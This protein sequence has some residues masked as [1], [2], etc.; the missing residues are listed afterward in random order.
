MVI[1][2]DQWVLTSSLSLDSLELNLVQLSSIL[3]LWIIIYE[4]IINY[5]RLIIKL[6]LIIKQNYFIILF[7]R[8]SLNSNYRIEFIIYQIYLNPYE[9]LKFKLILEFNLNNSKDKR[10]MPLLQWAEPTEVL[11]LARLRG[12]THLALLAHDKNRGGLLPHQRQRL[13][14]KIRSA[15][16]RRWSGQ[17]TSPIDGE[18]DLGYGEVRAHRR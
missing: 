8:L 17:G 14:G 4:L 9:F 15:G 6:E 16:G 10:E 2:H 1:T 7:Q 12:L 3:E 11:G 18:L 13:V 5:P